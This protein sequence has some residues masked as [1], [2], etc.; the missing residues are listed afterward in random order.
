MRLLISFIGLLFLNSCAISV[1]IVD[2]PIVFKQKRVKLTQDYLENRY[3][4]SQDNILIKPQMIVVHWTAIPTL[5]KSFEAF[6]NESLPNWRPELV[7]QSALN[8]SAQFLVDQDGTIYRLMP[9]NHMARHVIG[10][11]HAA[12][13]IENVGGTKETPLTKAQLKSNIKLIKY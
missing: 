9:E 12:I 5:E 4:M 7:N 1:P 3:G 6:Y 10:L 2:K 8:V 13:G 11:N